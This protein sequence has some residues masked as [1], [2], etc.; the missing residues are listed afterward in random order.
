MPTQ[1]MGTVMPANRMKFQATA[2]ELVWMKTIINVAITSVSKTGMTLSAMIRKLAGTNV[3]ITPTTVS[4][5]TTHA[6]GHD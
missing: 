6:P 5:A 2:A 4:T 3:G 1:T